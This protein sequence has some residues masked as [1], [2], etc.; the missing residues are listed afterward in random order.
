MKEILNEVEQELNDILGKAGK[1]VEEVIGEDKS[2]RLKRFCYFYGG[3]Y[4]VG[5]YC[6]RGGEGGVGG[7]W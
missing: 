2:K 7:K 4:E 6:E 5:R 3:G 1:E